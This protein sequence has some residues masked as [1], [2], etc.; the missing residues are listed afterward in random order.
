MNEGV[1]VAIITGGLTLIGTIITVMVG[2]SKAIA[3]MDKNQAVTDTKL[4]ALTDE[5]K[6]HNNFA[7]RIPVL[8]TQIEMVSKRV[9]MLEK[10]SKKEG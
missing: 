1:I 2:N 9:D 5:V 8:E 4:D 10:T 7:S 3:T 6:K